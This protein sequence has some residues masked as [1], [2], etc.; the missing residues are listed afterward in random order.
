MQTTRRYTAR[1]QLWPVHFVERP[2]NSVHGN[3]IHKESFVNVN[4]LSGH[5]PKFQFYYV[6]KWTGQAA[7]VLPLCNLCCCLIHVSIM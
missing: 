3:D 6:I 7:N 4:M 2:M 5:R 1:E